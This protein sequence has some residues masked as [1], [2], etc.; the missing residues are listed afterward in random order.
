MAAIIA[1]TVVSV[2][3]PVGPLPASVYWRRRAL[4]LAVVIVVLLLV[5]AVLP[6]GGGDDRPRDTAAAAG[7]PDPTDPAA[8]P[9]GLTATAPSDDPGR[10]G[11]GNGAGNG[12]GTGVGGAVTPGATTPSPTPV[13]TTPKPTP[14]APKAC[15]DSALQVTVNPRQPAYTVGQSPY[16]DLKIRNIS[17]LACIRDVSASQQ[18]IVLMRGAQR[19]WSSNDCGAQDTTRS[20]QLLQPGVQLTSS[21]HWTG[22]GSRP[23]CA[24]KRILVGAGTYALVGRLGTIVSRRTP[25]VLR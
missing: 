4:A 22:L 10:A 17:T 24:G 8:A 16:L 6:G 19:L 9:T 20:D 15:A 5:W 11:D 23:K 12:A 14:A 2:L 25:I 1:T 18:E 7:S 3:D 21:V 13:P